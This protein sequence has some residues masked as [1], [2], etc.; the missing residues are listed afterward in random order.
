M[1]LRKH[2]KEENGKNKIYRSMET[3]LRSCAVTS[4]SGQ[5]GS[6]KRSHVAFLLFVMLVLH[7]QMLSLHLMLRCEAGV[8]MVSVPH[9]LEFQITDCHSS[10]LVSV[11]QIGFLAQC[12][13]KFDS[14]KAASASPG[15]LLEMQNLKL[16][17]RPT[18]S[19]SSL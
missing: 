18:K 3:F 10:L 12:F 19:G 1:G 15:S 7:P 4:V 14:G 9:L 5:H 13:S 11:L 16:H 6:S 17:P 2:H 8:I